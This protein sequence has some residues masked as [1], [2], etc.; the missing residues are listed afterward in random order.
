MCFALNGSSFKCSAD[1]DEWIR[2]FVLHSKH[3]HLSLDTSHTFLLNSARF[4]VSSLD[5]H[6]RAILVLLCI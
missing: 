5:S 2:G 1:E 6:L 4:F 3:W